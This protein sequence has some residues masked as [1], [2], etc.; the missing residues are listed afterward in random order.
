MS[1]KLTTQKLTSL[2]QTC[3]SYDQKEGYGPISGIQ[4]IF[5]R[6]MAIVSLSALPTILQISPT[7]E[8]PNG[9][10]TQAFHQPLDWE[11]STLPSRPTELRL[12]TCKNSLLNDVFVMPGWIRRSTDWKRATDRHS[13]HCLFV[14]HHFNNKLPTTFANYFTH[15]HHSQT[16]RRLKTECNYYTPRY[17]IVKLQ[18]SIKYLGVSNCP[19]GIQFQ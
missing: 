5:K 11:S 12:P 16:T 7:I 4:R 9:N 17:R 8:A 2:Q 10:W 14:Y 1:F 19:F 3:P 13:R 15:H 6:L 18:R